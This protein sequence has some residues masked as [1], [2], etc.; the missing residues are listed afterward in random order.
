MFYI[1]DTKR[2]LYQ[3]EVI[4]KNLVLNLGFGD[5]TSG[6]MK[7][8]MLVMATFMSGVYYPCSA[9]QKSKTMHCAILQNVSFKKEP[10]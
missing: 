8:A 10:G 4:A 2:A 5:P 7:D 3:L 9:S 6:P 1:R